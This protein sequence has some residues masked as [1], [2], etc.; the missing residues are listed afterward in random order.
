MYTNA[1]V[2]EQAI[3]LILN[4]GSTG[5]I[6]TQQLM[7]Q[8]G[9]QV[10]CAASARI[11]MANRA[12]KTPISKINN[13]FFEVNDITVPIKVLVMK[14]TQYQKAYQVL[15]TNTDHNKLL[16]ILS[17]DNKRK[18]KE[19]DIP[20]KTGKEK[21]GLHLIKTIGQE[22]T[23]IASHAI[24]NAMAIQ[25]NKKSGTM[26]YVSLVINK[27]IEH[28]TQQRYL[29]TYASKGKGKLQTPAVT[30]KQIQPPTWKKTR[31]KSPTNSLYHYIPGSAIS[32]T[33]TGISTSHSKQKKEDL[34]RPY[35]VYFEGFKS[36]LPTPSG[37]QSPPPQL[38]FGTV[39]SWEVM[40][41]KKEQEEKEEEESEDQE[42][43]YQNPIP[44]NPNIEILNFQTQQNLNLEN[45]EIETP[46]FQM[47]P[48]QNNQN[49]DL[50]NQQ[51]LPSGI[52]INQPLAELI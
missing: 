17:W 51:N 33:S 49:P 34:L 11:I 44:E 46:N 30:L 13:F 6:I 43:T 10:D 25:K 5:S 42:F 9:Y 27:E 40:E 21:L 23:I 3:K 7:D 15:W 38:D 41:L 18:G 45:L 52:I 32:I 28:Y 36:Q 47:Q 50:I 35:S 19:E 4:S 14:A 8:L 12:T 31:V 39:S 29:I 1:K 2:D 20:E 26:N 48:N 16:L 37:L 24:E 22:L